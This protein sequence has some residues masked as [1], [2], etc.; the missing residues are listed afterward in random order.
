MCGPAPAPVEYLGTETDWGSMYDVSDCPGFDFR[1]GAY[2]ALFERSDATPFQHPVWLHH[3]YSVLAP[4]RGAEPL[5]II[6]RQDDGRLAMVL[7]LL[8]L[9]RGPL[10]VVEFADLGVCDYCSPVCDRA[11]FNAILGSERTRDRLLAAIRPCDLLRV[12]KVRADGL[13]LDRLFGAACTRMP[14]SAHSLPLHSPYEAWRSMSLAPGLAREI[15]RKWRRLQRSGSVSFGYVTDPAAIDATFEEMRTFRRP[16]FDGRP[17]KDLLQDPPYLRFY[18]NVATGG[19]G[20]AC[21]AR[22]S[23]DERTVAATFG[24]RYAGTF[25]E[26]LRSFDMQ[27]YKNMSVGMLMTDALIAEAVAQGDLH[28]D[29]TIGDEPYKQMFAPVSTPLYA[30]SASFT[31]IGK[32]AVMAAERLP[33]VHRA[34][35]RLL[36]A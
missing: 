8:R 1:S 34:A 32:L 21:L 18:K 14:D 26:L 22:L 29:L 35:K 12:E 17:G 16:R 10:A 5:I 23:V 27:A 36:G 15:E 2:A 19:A 9:R 28:Y 33:Q 20:Y 31:V 24:L 6:M 7:P 11:T 13:P 3:L 25:L 30:L 4:A